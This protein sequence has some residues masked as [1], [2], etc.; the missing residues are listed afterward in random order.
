LTVYSVRLMAMP[1]K[2]EYGC[3][4]VRGYK[5]AETKK[6]AHFKNMRGRYI[7]LYVT[8]DRLPQ[9]G[10]CDL[11]DALRQDWPEVSDVSMMLHS[12]WPEGSERSDGCAWALVLVG[13]TVTKECHPGQ[14][15]RCDCPA[16]THNS[17]V[18]SNTWCTRKNLCVPRNWEF[19]H[20]TRILDVIMLKYPLKMRPMPGMWVQSVPVTAIPWG[21]MNT[22]QRNTLQRS[23]RQDD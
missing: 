1:L 10:H 11:E 22:E 23:V 15:C 20:A 7:V 17:N 13:E 19:R 12:P 6:T 2:Y 16:H 14:A 8:E 18:S 5:K 4:M 9:T 3:L 21:G